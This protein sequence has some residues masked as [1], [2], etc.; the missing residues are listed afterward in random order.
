MTRL[1]DWLIVAFLALMLLAELAFVIF[2]AIRF[3]EAL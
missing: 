1:V 2:A 3:M